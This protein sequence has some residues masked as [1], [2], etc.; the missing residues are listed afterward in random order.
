MVRADKAGS[1]GSQAAKRECSATKNFPAVDLAV[2]RQEI[3]NL[4]GNKALGMVEKATQDFAETG[5]ITTL[6]YLFEMIGLFPCPVGVQE[7]GDDDSLTMTLLRRLGAPEAHLG[8]S[9]V[10]ND[11]GVEF[12]RVAGDAVE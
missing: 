12:V 6:K 4:V 10:T 7:N 9:E 11:S 1:K 5:S 2:V 3:V 8:E